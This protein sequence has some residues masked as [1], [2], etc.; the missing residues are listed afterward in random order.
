MGKRL[1]WADITRI[2]AIYFI[3]VLHVNSFP[4]ASLTNF[5]YCIGLTLANTCVPLLVMV[6][7]ALLIGKKESYTSFFRKRVV[8]VIIPWITWTCIFTLIVLYFQAQF[9]PK[10]VIHIFRSIFIPFFW[11]IVLIC[12][13]YLITPAL[14]IFAQ[15]ARTKDIFLI[16][17]LWYCALCILPYIRNTQAFP[18]NVGNG[19]VQLVVNFIGYFLLG[20]LIIRI[21]P[22]K[23]YKPFI[24]LL[25]ILSLCVRSFLE[26]YS[27]HYH[28]QLF[29]SGSEFIDPS[30]VIV[31]A[32]LFS[33]LYLS[34]D[35]YQSTLSNWIKNKLSIISKAT[36][37][38]YFVHYLFL[39]RAPLPMLISTTSLIHV[40]YNID[41]FLN[42]FIFFI[43][44]L[45]I[46]LLLQKV[47]V[48]RNLIT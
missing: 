26:Y 16:I 19:I 34:E 14:R 44:S 21:K 47:P 35:F 25:F 41:M 45:V 40:S 15:N 17:L 33:L 4:N 13:L 1:V 27:L 43:I 32:S 24:A 18:L 11:F 5:V 12:S 23:K 9:D 22:N 37:G 28:K 39:N 38:I 3:L 8:K 10:T 7:G 36:L 46:I 2:F 29:L 30:L 31:S 48:I 20:F 42:A 6:S